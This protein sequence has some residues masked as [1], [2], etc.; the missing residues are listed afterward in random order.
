MNK[1]WMIAVVAALVLAIGLG[2]MALAQ[3]A[4][5]TPNGGTPGS[6][7]VNMPNQQTGIWV[8]G[9][10]KVTLAPD[11]AIL[12]VGVQSQASTVAEA[13]GQAAEAMD[14]VMKALRDK[15]VASKDIQTRY[16]SID[17][18]TRWTTRPDR[19]GPGIQSL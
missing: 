14:K 19:G 7:T 18:V 1:F 11:V 15:G 9:V 12:Q 8:N 5:D 2:G 6:V 10:G 16:F 17:K 3:N 4:G 13:Q